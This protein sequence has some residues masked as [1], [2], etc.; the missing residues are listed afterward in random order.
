VATDE[1][2]A[3]IRRVEQ[4]YEDIGNLFQPN[5]EAVAAP[6]LDIYAMLVSEAAKITEQ[7]PPLPERPRVSDMGGAVAGRA[8]QPM[9]GQ[10]CA[11]LKAVT[12]YDGD[13]LVF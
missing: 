3:L 1:E 9:V 12:K 5:I 8:L 7:T 4:F 11:W 10:L 13:S 2:R 6:Y